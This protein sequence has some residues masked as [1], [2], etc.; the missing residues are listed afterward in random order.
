MQKTRMTLLACIILMYLFFTFL[1]AVN[2]KAQGDTLYVDGVGG[3]YYEDISSALADASDGHTI[4]VYNGTYPDIISISKTIRLI[5]ENK[6]NTIIKGI[7]PRR[8][9]ITITAPGV[10]IQNFTIQDC[11][12]SAI[13]IR[14]DNNVIT[15]NI[16]SNNAQ[17]I[18]VRFFTKN[19]KIYHNNFLNNKKQA[20]DWGKNDWDAGSKLGGNHWSDFDEPSEG[21]YDKNNDGIVDSPY[22]VTKRISRDNYPLIEKDGWISDGDGEEEPPL[23]P[24]KPPDN[25]TNGP[26]PNGKKPPEKPGPIDIPVATG[27][28]TIAGSISVL[29]H[30]V[31]NIKKRTGWEK[32]SKEKNPP[33]KC[34]ACTYFCQKKKLSGKYSPLKIKHITLNSNGTEYKIKG[35]IAD[36]FN[37]LIKN[38]RRGVN[39]DTFNNQLMQ[40]SIVLFGY[41]AKFLQASKNAPDVL[42]TINLVGGNVECEFILKHC[43]PVG[44]VNKWVDER[45][46][47]VTLKEEL[48]ERLGLLRNID[49]DDEQNLKR[50]IAALTKMILKFINR[51]DSIDSKYK[52][53]IS[54]EKCKPK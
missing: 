16:I 5:G 47:K 9:T 28:V 49:L 20:S 50:N 51:Y 52:L 3:E 33:K 10:I 43:K 48:D 19:N 34:Q 37:N 4:F 38:F 25:G 17:G 18:R 29:G 26:E 32:K 1:L 14:S 36:A 45:S 21:A 41:V 24:P 42:I 22:D 40:L 30:R 6:T 39:T 53:S 13:D 2:V 46:W 12:K 23:P 15:N 44:A 7:S 27:V 54:T 8:A 11:Q 31:V 35:K